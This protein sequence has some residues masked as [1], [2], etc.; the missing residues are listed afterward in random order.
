MKLL[1]EALGGEAGAD[2]LLRGE[3]K[4]TKVRPQRQFQVWQTCTIGRYKTL[5]EYCEVLSKLG[6]DLTQLPEKYKRVQFTQKEIEVPLT[7]VSQSALKIRN[8]R[9]EGY[10]DPHFVCS[11]AQRMGLDLLTYE[12]ALA[13]C[14]L[15]LKPQPLQLGLMPSSYTYIDED[16]D[17]C[18]G[19]TGLSISVDDNGLGKLCSTRGNWRDRIEWDLSKSFVFAIGNTQ[20]L[21]V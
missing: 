13:L 19:Y 7:L 18:V 6:A 11:R 9:H 1:L 10:C 16:D 8:T 4:I 2:K 21:K 20:D 3:T 17:D 14:L 5:E 12:M 15:K